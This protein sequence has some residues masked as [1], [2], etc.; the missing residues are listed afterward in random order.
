MVKNSFRHP[1]SKEII[2]GDAIKDDEP[3]KPEPE[4]SPEHEVARES[5]HILEHKNRE[6]RSANNI[7]ER[8]HPEA[9]QTS[10]TRG[11]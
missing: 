8:N 3:E 6:N 11:W 2:S 5:P 4:T 9:N 1:A 10:C 7:G